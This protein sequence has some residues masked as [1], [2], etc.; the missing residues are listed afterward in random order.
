MGK[1][2]RKPKKDKKTSTSTKMGKSPG[3]LGGK[4]P[5][6]KGKV[7]C[8][9]LVYIIYSILSLW[10]YYVLILILLF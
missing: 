8:V 10:E 2:N 9:H 4:L 1:K 7:E 6:K 3:A 5:T